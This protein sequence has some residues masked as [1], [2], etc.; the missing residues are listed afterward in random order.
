MSTS[1]HPMYING[2]WRQGSEGDLADDI[3]VDVRFVRNRRVVAVSRKAA[4]AGK[5]VWLRSRK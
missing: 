1:I 5:E 4:S 3:E 2:A